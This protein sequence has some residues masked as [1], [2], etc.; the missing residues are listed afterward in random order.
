MYFARVSMVPVVIC[1]A[2]RQMKKGALPLGSALV[3]IFSCVFGAA[4][5]SRSRSFDP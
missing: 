4:V 2:V 1:F 5:A 3:L